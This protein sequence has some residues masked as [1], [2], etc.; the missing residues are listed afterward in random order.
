LRKYPSPPRN[1]AYRWTNENLISKNF[2]FV[3]EE[4][5]KNTIVF[6]KRQLALYF[7]TQSNIISTVEQNE[8]TYEQVENWLDKEL[9]SFFDNDETTQTI[10]YGNWIKS[11]QRTN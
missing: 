11:I 9:S 1:D 2:T 8:T 6:N 3:S 10:N 7:T 4:R 5:F